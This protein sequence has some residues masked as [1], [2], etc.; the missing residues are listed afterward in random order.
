ML[1]EGIAI[2]IKYY[3]RHSAC[4]SAAMHIGTTKIFTCVLHTL[5]TI[6]RSMAKCEGRVR[7]IDANRN[8]KLFGKMLCGQFR[9]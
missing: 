2:V 3:V 6:A 5:P 1:Y 9:Q 4:P 7:L 8:K